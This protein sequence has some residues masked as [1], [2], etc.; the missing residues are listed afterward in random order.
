MTKNLDADK[1]SCFG[2]G[3]EFDACESFSLFNDNNFGKNG[4]VLSTCMGHLCMLIIKS[5][6]CWFLVKSQP[7]V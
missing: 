1:Y 2:Y 3:S 6:L 5:N 7:M 4:E